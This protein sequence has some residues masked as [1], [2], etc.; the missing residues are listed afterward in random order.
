M[1]ERPA[2]SWSRLR[3]RR[4]ACVRG[5]HAVRGTC[6][7]ARTL[8]AAAVGDPVGED[9]QGRHGGNSGRS[10]KVSRVPSVTQPVPFADEETA[11]QEGSLTSLGA[12]HQAGVAPGCE[13]SSA[14]KTELLPLWDATNRP[15]RPRRWLRHSLLCWKSR[16][17]EQG[18]GCACNFRETLRLAYSISESFQHL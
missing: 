9:R 10:L 14:T 17:L 7:W 5:A 2:C 11:S 6:Q 4:G 12:P 3:D 13:P 18:P 15:G 1:A 16:S 8:S